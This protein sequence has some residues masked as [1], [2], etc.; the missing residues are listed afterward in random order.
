M[1]KKD[2]ESVVR[3]EINSG[4]FTIPAGDKVYEITVRQSPTISETLDAIVVNEL[5]S[6]G[7]DIKAGSMHKNTP[8]EEGSSPDDL[9]KISLYKEI[10][11]DM[12]KDIGRLARDLSIS[13][14]D[15]PSGCQKEVD[16]EKAGLDL[17]SAKSMLEEV[18]NMTETATMTIMDISEDMQGQCA[19]ISKTLDDVRALDFVGNAEPGTGIP[20]KKD[21]IVLMR[22][23]LVNMKN[24]RDS[25]SALLGGPNVDPASV[26][27]AISAIDAQV[28]ML[29]K[30]YSQQCDSSDRYMVVDESYSM[31]RKEDHDRLIA[32]LESSDHV[33]Q[34]I[35]SNIG[36][37]LESLTFQD[38]SGQR[39]I[40]IVGL[41]SNVQIQLLSILVSSGVK[42]KYLREGKPIE[43]NKADAEVDELMHR[44]I[45]ESNKTGNS[46]NV[47]DQGAIDSLL[48]D[49]GF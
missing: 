26:K 27:E 46:K 11:E 48:D 28:A 7:V 3:I 6:A 45:D 49:L 9:Q 21:P 42:L 17:E 18:V 35:I 1:K 20:K 19:I 24:L 16:F 25:L 8:E 34:C 15:L 30:E 38:L 31:V 29:E 12:F 37:I 33:I 23:M 22:D 44:F 13:I 5:S 32:A 41:L 10:S 2:T 14:K 36:R 43:K 39:I 40:K 4:T 47:L